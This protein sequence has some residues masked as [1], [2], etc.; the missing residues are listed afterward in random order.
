[1]NAITPV[2]GLRNANGI[3]VV[4]SREVAEH[5]EKRHDNVLRDIEALI[6]PPSDLR[7]GT[8]SMAYGTNAPVKSWFVESPY[9]D[10]NGLSRRSFDMTRDGFSLLVMGW[11][12]A[13]AM[14]FKVAYID[15][16]NR[17]EETLRNR[18]PVDLNDA[19]TLR[20]LLIDY[21]GRVLALE[22]VN[23]EMAPKAAALDRIS[24]K[25]GES[26]LQ[27][28]SKELFGRAN[29]IFPVLHA[30]GWIYRRDTWC[31]YQ[32]YVSRGF[33]AVR[34][35]ECPDGKARSQTV[36]TPKGRAK[37]AEGLSGLRQAAAAPG[38][39]VLEALGV[40]AVSV[41]KDAGYL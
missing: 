16:F 6:L 29:A 41:L 2:L 14:R 32:E 34:E 17:M 5:F 37:L 40:Q 23:A 27:Q 18:P 28:A 36:I 30:I 11:T 1:M 13:K 24:A 25:D 21:S 31:P 26:S 19:A 3:P 20:N 12:G 38:S 35:I 4:N 7:V 39:I 22:Q 8:E 33:L 9:I 15:A 10:P